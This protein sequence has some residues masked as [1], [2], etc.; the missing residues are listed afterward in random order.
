[1]ANIV[2]F[3]TIWSN[4]PGAPGYSNM[5]VSGAEDPTVAAGAASA[6]HDFF[7]AVRVY[8]PSGT[9]LQVQ[10]VG[11]IIDDATGQITGQVS[12]T[13]PASSAGSGTGVYS[14]ASGVLVDW[15]TATYRNGRRVRGRTYIVP[16]TSTAY[17]SNGSIATGVLN[18][19]TSAATTLLAALDGS[20]VVWSRPTAAH[21]TGGSS[22]ITGATVPDLAVVMRSRRT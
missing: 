5:Y 9:T 11:D 6:I 21:P 13:Q 12:F 4:F 2:R 19:V 14:G 18:A 17:D 15:L 1:M 16:V 8:V 3:R 7:D 22:V 20:M 10:G